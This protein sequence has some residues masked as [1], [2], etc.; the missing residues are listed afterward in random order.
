MWASLA[1]G[2]WREEAIRNVVKSL[3]FIHFLSK[4]V[5]KHTVFIPFQ[6]PGDTGLP[7]TAQ[8]VSEWHSKSIEEHKKEENELTTV[9]ATLNEKNKNSYTS[10]KSKNEAITNLT[11]T[12]LVLEN[13]LTTK[14][15]KFNYKLPLVEETNLF[16]QEL[17]KLTTN[18][19]QK[20][21]N[22]EALKASITV[23][24]AND[25]NIVTKNANLKIFTSSIFFPTQINN[26]LLHKVA[27]A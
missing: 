15:A 1:G 9:I 25:N 19:N 16:I 10:I 22:L 7:M 17:N 13:N 18:F 2:S 6:S 5:E 12:C 4:R 8:F 26:K 14:L 20:E 23:I 21:K 24:H 3:G 27:D 11:K